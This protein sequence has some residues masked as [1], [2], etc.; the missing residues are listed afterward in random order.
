[1]KNDKK[2]KIE[3]DKKIKNY[4]ELLNISNKPNKLYDKNYP[5]PK[6]K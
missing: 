6:N 4:K 1:M 3:N 5:L 2:K